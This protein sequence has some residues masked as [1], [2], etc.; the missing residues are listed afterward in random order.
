M[1]L[2]VT[3]LK[4]IFKENN[5]LSAHRNIDLYRHLQSSNDHYTLF[6]FKDDIKSVLPFIGITPMKFT[7][8]IFEYIISAN[9]H[10]QFFPTNTFIHSF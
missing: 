4:Q 1:I 7:E 6:T 2:K 8:R 9:M 10:C 3:Q 5:Y